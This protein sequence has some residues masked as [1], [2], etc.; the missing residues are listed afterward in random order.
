MSAVKF[1]EFNLKKNSI[2]LKETKK[3]I[4]TIIIIKE[5]LLKLNHLKKIY[6][7]EKKSNQKI[8]L[9]Y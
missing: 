3:K 1:K 9:R 4:P 6:K 8:K 2:I 7:N 5:Q